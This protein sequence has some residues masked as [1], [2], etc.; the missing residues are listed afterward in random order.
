M[1]RAADDRGGRHLSAVVRAQA[2]RA[3]RQCRRALHQGHR[4]VA[5]PEGRARPLAGR[6]LHRAGRIRPRAGAA[7]RRR[8]PRSAAGMGAA[9]E[10]LAARQPAGRQ[11]SR[12]AAARARRGHRRRHPS[13][14]ARRRR[15]DCQHRS[16]R[17]RAR[18]A[19]RRPDRVR[20][21][22]AGPDRRS[23]QS[24][25]PERHRERRGARARGWRCARRAPARSF[26]CWRCWR[27][28]ALRSMRLRR[29][30]RSARP[31]PTSRRRCA[32]AAPTAASPRA[33]WRTRPGLGFVPLVWER[34][35]LA[36]R[37]RDY[38]LPRAAGAVQVH[39]QRQPFASAPANSAATTS[40]R[41]AR[42]GSSIEA[43][44]GLPR[45]V[46]DYSARNSADRAERWPSGLRR[47]SALRVHLDVK[48]RAPYGGYQERWPSGLR[49]TLGKRVYGKPYRGFESHPLRQSYRD[50]HSLRAFER[51]E[52]SN[53]GERSRKI[54]ILRHIR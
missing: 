13:A 11:R 35:D 40:A 24:A 42:C 34:F 27:A 43:G 31:G 49:R 1:T 38:F 6:R 33:R 54:S 48:M 15:R 47:T 23:R 14:P 25:R 3:R 50:Q 18:A 32:P 30:S 2:L 4:Q 37:Q 20:A 51:A 9:R 10:R 12:A 5:V 53:D 39:P 29:S 17:Q 41:P 8:Q 26:C 21:A 7:D 36:L 44:R 22:R 19:R 16:R 46:A 28:R 52:I 45:R